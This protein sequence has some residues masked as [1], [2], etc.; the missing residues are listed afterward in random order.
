MCAF[1]HHKQKKTKD[2]PLRD[3]CL[4]CAYDTPTSTRCVFVDRF[5]FLSLFSSHLKNALRPLTLNLD[6][7]ISSLLLSSSSLTRHAH[8]QLVSRV[9]WFGSIWTPNKQKHHVNNPPLAQKIR[10]LFRPCELC[11]TSTTTC[12][13]LTFHCCCRTNDLARLHKINAR[14]CVK[15]TSQPLSHNTCPNQCATRQPFLNTPLV[16]TPDSVI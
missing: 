11:P 8:H 12:L 7:P 9:P 6:I 3:L 4:P 16:D 10:T 13:M 15:I 14:L 1:S 2:S 5:M